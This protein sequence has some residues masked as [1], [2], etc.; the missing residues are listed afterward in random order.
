VYQQAKVEVK[1]E[2]NLS[3]GISEARQPS[4]A[5]KMASTVVRI[6]GRKLETIVVGNAGG[7]TSKVAKAANNEQH[8]ATTISER[9]ISSLRQS[10][11]TKPQNVEARPRPQAPSYMQSGYFRQEQQLFGE[12][13]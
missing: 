2:G 1:G 5:D 8:S 11:P 9:T 3:Y 12:G 7:T 6:A 4:A 10:P 13:F